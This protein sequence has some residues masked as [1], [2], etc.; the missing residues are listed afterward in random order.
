MDPGS[1]NGMLFQTND[2]T[3]F[4]NSVLTAQLEDKLLEGE[5]ANNVSQASFFV[6]FSGKHRSTGDVHTSE[7]AATLGLT[8]ASKLLK[9]MVNMIKLRSL[10]F[11][12]PLGLIPSLHIEAQV[13]SLK[14][15]SPEVRQFTRYDA[16]SQDELRLL[17]IRVVD[18]TGSPALEDQTVTLRNGKIVDVSPTKADEHADGHR[19][20]DLSGRTVLP[21]LVGMHD[22]LFYI[23]RAADNAEHQTGFPTLLPQM[24]YSAPRLYIANGVTT[25]RTTG[26]ME[27]YTDLNLRDAIEA[28]EI[29]GPHLDVTGPYLIGEGNLFL[30]MHT[31]HGP[32]E[33][34]KMVDYW[35]DQGVT[36]FKA[37]T[38]LTRAEL[39]AAI[40]EVHARGLKITGHLCSVT[41][42]EAAEMGIDNLEHGFTVNT[43]LD[44]G[45]QPDVCPAT[46]GLP[47]QEAMDP[48]GPD[49]K[50]L[51]ALL[52]QHHVA[53]TSTL[54]V[55]EADGL[56]NPPLRQR[57]LDMLSPQAR[58]TYLYE[59]NAQMTRRR[60]ALQRYRSLFKREELF[61]RRFVQAGGLL[62]AGPD[63]TSDGHIIPGF[64]DQREIELL[65]DAGFS[66]V[67][68]IKIGT[69][70]G[71][72]YLG[73]ADHI[74]SIQAGKDADLMIV[75]GNPSSNINDIENVEWVVQG[76]RVYDSA[77]LLDS[78][79]G[80]YGLY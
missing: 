3:K 69:L 15:P 60:E 49:G 48:D 39:K 18:G 38:N 36:S 74:G 7:P 8:Q 66:P 54:P 40:D 32:E 70:N 78:I 62:M 75:R 33:T 51:I 71:A 46:Q 13:G 30:Q 59:R 53:V 52:I 26:S 61:E 2:S 20:L 9:S 58:E 10:S 65:V 27:P 19:A 12:L 45:K 11:V 63:P 23:A 1:Q 41:Y 68:A 16:S 37:Y 73:R 44:P 14:T 56:G 72:T 67:Q 28:L 4:V 80:S 76:G 29:P 25:A 79:K 6:R 64:G 22:H 57:A 42:P 77:A 34:R 47:T 43:Q 50:A 24:T 5:S 17:H 35:A 31:L 21:G 55:D